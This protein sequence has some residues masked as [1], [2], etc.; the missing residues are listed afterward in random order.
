MSTTLSTRILNHYE[1]L[2]VPCI[3]PKTNSVWVRVDVVVL[4]IRLLQKMTRFRLHLH[5]RIPVR[6]LLSRRNPPQVGLWESL[7]KSLED[8]FYSRSSSLYFSPSSKLIIDQGGE[9]FQYFAWCW[10]NCFAIVVV[11]LRPSRSDIAINQSAKAIQQRII[12][13]RDF[14]MIWKTHT[15]AQRFWGLSRIPTPHEN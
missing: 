1:P 10:S 9:I 2:E 13:S 7:S 3:V 5:L 15:K 4:V 11:V 6:T 8:L 14:F 12:Y